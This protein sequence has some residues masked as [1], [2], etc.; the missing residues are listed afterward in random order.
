MVTKHHLKELGHE[1]TLVNHVD[2]QFAKAW[3]SKR[4]LGEIK[5][6]MLKYMFV[7]DVVEKKQTTLANVS[8]SSNKADL[9]TKCHTFGTRMKGCAMLGLKLR[10]DDG[11]FA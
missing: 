3:A 6:V 4:R 2:S 10:R 9:M 1:V 8:T 11:K 5:H 7:Q